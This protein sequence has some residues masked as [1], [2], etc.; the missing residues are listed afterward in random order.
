M[1]D[2]DSALEKLTDESRRSFL[3]KSAITSGGLAMGLSG[4]S[5]VAAQ[6][7]NDQNGNEQNGN[8][9]RGVMFGSQFH[10]RARFEIVSQRIDWAPLENE[11]N[12][13]L[14]DANDDLLFDDSEVFANFNT[15]VV[16]YRIGRQSWAL[17]FV[18]EDANVQQGQTYELSP[19][20][21]AFGPDDFQQFGID[22][23]DYDGFYGPDENNFGNTGYNEL[24]MVTVQFSPAGGGGQGGGGQDG[25]DGNQTDGN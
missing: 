25:G 13:F 5:T 3:K 11:E 4:G 22:A 14:T 20:F 19:A 12:D 7:G 15:R 6:D 2:N 8:V 17:L 18:Q 10:P 23:D 16:N 9:M 1:T 21:G 24:G